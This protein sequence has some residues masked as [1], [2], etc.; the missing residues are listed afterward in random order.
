MIS[1]SKLL[2]I[3]GEGAIGQEIEFGIKLSHK[4]LD[5]MDVNQIE[6]VFSRYNPS[7]VLCL[8]SIDL[9]N[10]EK[11]PSLAFQVNVVG[12]YNVAIQAKKRNI[13]IILISSGAIFN[14]LITK[15]FN[16]KDM[17]EPL[18][19]YGQTKYLAE[20][21]LQQTAP[22]YLIV[23]TGWIFGLTH[24]KN[25]FTKFIDNLL[26]SKDTTK[27]TATQDSVGSQTYIL[28]FVK[29]LKD[30]IISGKKG[31]IHV[32][33]SGSASASD[34]AKEAINFLRSNRTIE[35]TIS[36]PVLGQPLRSKSE[37]LNSYCVKMRSWEEALEDYIKSKEL[38]K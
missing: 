10:S 4:D 38:H 31:I 27:I 16:E 18:N 5:I 7:A 8:A 17:P 37:A 13:P 6:E 3:G 9:A 32:V 34:V 14:G 20:L 25:G 2:I 24:K 35:P 23:R 19:I 12:L 26:D 28:D 1:L 33:N 11:N 30:A 22:N 36:Q 29:H 21:L 15:I